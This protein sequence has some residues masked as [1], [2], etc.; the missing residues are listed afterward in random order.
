MN[1]LRVLVG[2]VSSWTVKG[3]RSEVLC[4]ARVQDYALERDLMAKGFEPNGSGLFVA[5]G[6]M[7]LS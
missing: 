2:R 6:L 7:H 3:Q 1:D 5:F 4:P